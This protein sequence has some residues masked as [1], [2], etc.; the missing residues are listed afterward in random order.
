[1]KSW[2]LPG[3]ILLILIGCNRPVE[4]NPAT[5]SVLRVAV[6][7]RCIS[8]DI[9]SKFLPDFGREN[10]CRIVIVPC[11]S[12]HT[13]RNFL[14]SEDS[15]KA[16]VLVGLDQLTMASLDNDTLFQ[17]YQGK[18]RKLLDRELMIEKNYRFIPISYSQ[19]A[20][21]YNSEEI[22]EPPATFGEMQDGIWQDKIIILDPRTSSLGNAMLIWSLAL[23]GEHG[24]NHFWRSIKANI[25]QVA[26]NWDDAYQLFLAGEA[27]LV[28]GLSTFPLFH[29]L[30]ENNHIYKSFIPKEG[31]F[32]LIEGAVI[33]ARTAHP[34]LSQSFIDLL[35]SADFQQ[36]MISSRW[37]LPANGN[38]ELP[39]EFQNLPRVSK[40]FTGEISYNQLRKQNQLWIQKWEKTILQ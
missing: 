19:M 31:G 26:A 33:L 14:Q 28:L 17:D 9:W 7:E 35:L 2:L 20:F 16:D 15:L 8:S 12:T 24:Y 22:S 36:E 29:V 34:E 6:V 30:S 4:K 13:L 18:N 10:N 38:V 39:A 40:D 3:V 11:N 27:P 32:K 21:I 1:M 5:E 25:F 37:M 23:F